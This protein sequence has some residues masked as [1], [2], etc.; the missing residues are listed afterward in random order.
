MTWCRVDGDA[1]WSP[2]CSPA[3]SN[4]QSCFGDEVASADF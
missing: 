1:L 4:W 2:L 3:L